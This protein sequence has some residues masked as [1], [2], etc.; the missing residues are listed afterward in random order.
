ME[1]C[2]KCGGLIGLRQVRI[3]DDGAGSV[4]I[5]EILPIE[6]D[7]EIAAR[8][9]PGLCYSCSV[10]SNPTT[11]AVAYLDS[12]ER[13]RKSPY[14]KHMGPAV[15]RI[16]CMARM[17]QERMDWKHHAKRADEQVRRDNP[18]LNV[19]ERADR[20]ADILKVQGIRGRGGKELTAATI[21]RDCLRA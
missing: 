15:Q 12:L 5:T 10:F 1:K 9:L 18:A 20:V 4:C 21:K 6:Y 17:A 3:D 11:E 14:W 19:D 8:C 16:D 2:S 13:L 7:P